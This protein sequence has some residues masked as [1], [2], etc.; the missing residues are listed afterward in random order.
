MIRI[1]KLEVRVVR[2]PDIAVTL[3]D[4]TAGKQMAWQVEINGVREERRYGSE[5]K[6]YDRQLDV[7]AWSAAEIAFWTR[8]HSGLPQTKE[9]AIDFLDAHDLAKLRRAERAVTGRGR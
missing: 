5:L 2:A 4:G 6:A 3:R 7:Y 1:P 9:E 8:Q